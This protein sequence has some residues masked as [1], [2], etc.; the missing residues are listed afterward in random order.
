MYFVTWDSIRLHYPTFPMSHSLT[1]EEPIITTS[2]SGWSSQS[3]A[4]HNAPPMSST[5]PFS[6]ISIYHTILIGIL[7]RLTKRPSRRVCVWSGSSSVPGIPN[8]TEVEL[9]ILAHCLSLAAPE[10]TVYGK[11]RPLSEQREKEHHPSL[12]S[13]YGWVM[14]LHQTRGSCQSVGS[15]GGVRLAAWCSVTSLLASS[16]GAARQCRLRRPCERSSP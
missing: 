6:R 7:R 10:T 14:R 9:R 13:P 4:E 3:P 1:H 2:G 5:H 8:R 16:P 12:A 15:L 11:A